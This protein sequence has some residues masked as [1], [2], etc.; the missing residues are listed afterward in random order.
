MND[1]V[2]RLLISIQSD[3][4]ILRFDISELTT[5]FSDIVQDL[6]TFRSRQE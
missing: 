3:I 1:E 4:S 2:L 5:I 6:Q